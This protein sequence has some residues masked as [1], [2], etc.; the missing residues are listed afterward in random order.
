L[1]HKKRENAG[2]ESLVDY[3][4]D[5]MKKKGNSVEGEGEETP[6]VIDK[7][8]GCRTQKTSLGR[9]GGL[10]EGGEKQPKKDLSPLEKEEGESRGQLEKK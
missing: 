5:L 7:P 2:N 9:E 6:T 8:R 4:N 3:L 10:A 1:T